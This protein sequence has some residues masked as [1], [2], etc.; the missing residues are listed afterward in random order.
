MPA[1]RLAQ[2]EGRLSWRVT[3][4][5]GRP[6]NRGSAEAIAIGEWSP[7]VE[8]P[9][10]CSHG[11]HTTSQPHRWRGCRVWLV[12]GEG[13]GGADGDKAV[14]QRI[15]PLAEVDPAGPVLSA[16]IWIRCA[17]RPAVRSMRGAKLVDADLTGADL[18]GAYLVGA[19][20]TGAIM[21]GWERS[22]DGYAR[23]TV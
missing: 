17:P 18:T 15:R 12:E 6:A 16:S 19:D 5:H 23:R 20:L 21:P 1:A 10:I 13:L 7:T 2:R 9:Q 8:S 3:D 11:W 22:P 14:W 4:K